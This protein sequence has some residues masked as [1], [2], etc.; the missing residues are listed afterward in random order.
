VLD[1]YSLNESGPVAFARGGDHQILSPDLYV[2]V[3]D[4]EGR[5]CPPGSRGE[6]ALTGG[7]NPYLPLLRYRTADHAALDFSGPL[8][9]L[10]G[11]EGRPPSVFQDGQGG[12]FN[13]IDVTIALRDLPLPFFA[14]H[15]AADGALVF[16]TRCD[17]AT[18]AAAEQG[19]RTLFGPEPRLTIEMVP[20]TEPWQGKLIKYRSDVA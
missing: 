20:E 16:R 4:S 11:L 2:E 10:V 5:L 17:E 3:L 13:S 15:Q 6:I 18:K 7:N 8:P 9:V 1:I 14:L 19:L 12:I